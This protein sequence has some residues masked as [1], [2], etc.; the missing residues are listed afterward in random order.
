[1]TPSRIWT[2]ETERVL[3]SDHCSTSKPPRLDYLPF[4]EKKNKKNKQVFGNWDELDY[5]NKSISQCAPTNWPS[6]DASC[7]WVCKIDPPTEP[8][9]RYPPNQ[10]PQ[11]LIF[12]S[13]ESFK[14]KCKQTFL[15]WENKTQHLL[16]NFFNV[17]FFCNEINICY[18]SVKYKNTLLN[19]SIKIIKS[20]PKQ[21]C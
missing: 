2:T 15:G 6:V 18:S 7:L 10:G 17:K 13:F 8:K 16:I 20:A 4:R 21:K 19:C 12:G 5:S 3:L 11:Y 1:M 9:V 14:I